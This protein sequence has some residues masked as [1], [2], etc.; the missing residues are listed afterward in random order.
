MDWVYIDDVVDAL[1]S[2][3]TP[4]T[5]PGVVVDICGGDPITIRETL[6]RLGAIVGGAGSPR[7]GARPERIAEVAP[8]GDP[9][10]AAELL[11]WRPT[12]SLDDGLR[13]TVEWYAER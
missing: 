3:A 2:A 11:G 12:T 4:D 6:N 13:Q 10:P 8:V 7:F 9:D 5:C 1:L